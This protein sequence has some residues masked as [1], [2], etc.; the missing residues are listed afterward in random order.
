MLQ[1]FLFKGE[2][3]LE[4]AAAGGVPL[5]K[6]ETGKAVKLLQVALSSLGAA[7]PRSLAQNA[8]YDGIFGEETQR[9]VKT[10]QFGHGL[11]SDG[12]AGRHTLTALDQV[13][14]SGEVDPLV[15]AVAGLVNACADLGRDRLA[16]DALNPMFKNRLDAQTAQLGRVL[17]GSLS[18]IEYAKLRMYFLSNPRNS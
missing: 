16:G 14:S 4:A 18:E 13:L 10:F 8:V 11:Q 6:P 9:A 12:I 3:R 5:A 1:S 7:L 2:P 17:G 15:Q